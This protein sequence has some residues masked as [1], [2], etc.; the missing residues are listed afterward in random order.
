M[1]AKPGG[2]VVVDGHL[3]SKVD[4]EVVLGVGRMASEDRG[5]NE[6]LL[7][8]RLQSDLEMRSDREGL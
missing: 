7:E 8:K 5:A 2:M 6:T 1:K 4:L 3:M